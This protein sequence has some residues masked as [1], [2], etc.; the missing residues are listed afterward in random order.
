MGS[1]DIWDVDTSFLLLNTAK[2][3]SDIWGQNFGYY[4]CIAILCKSGI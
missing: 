2:F 4:Q 3:E 1:V